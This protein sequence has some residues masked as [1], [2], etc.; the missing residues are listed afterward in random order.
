[1]KSDKQG[2]VVQ[3][4]AKLTEIKVNVLGVVHTTH[5]IDIRIINTIPVF[6][7]QQVLNV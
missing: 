3:K 1:M 5:D 6:Q 4:Q 2:I 7:Q